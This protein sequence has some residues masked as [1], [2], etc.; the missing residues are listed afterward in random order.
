MKYKLLGLTL[1]LSSCSIIPSYRA[2]PTQ[3]CERGPYSSVCHGTVESR[4]DSE[5]FDYVVG[6]LRQRE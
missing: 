3:Y 1:L 4:Q 5:V 2:E 6:H